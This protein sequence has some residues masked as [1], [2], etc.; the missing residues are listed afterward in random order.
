MEH[1]SEILKKQA[2]A[3][4]S[5]ENT[6]TW[7]SADADPANGNECPVCKGARVVHPRL[8]SGQPDY[9]RT[10]PCRCVKSER[11][12]DRQSRL[13]Q[14]S[15]LGS[16]ARFTFDNL[17]PEGRSS[18]PRSQERFAQVFQAA[19]A[20]AADPKGWL[21]LSGPS[22]GGKTHIA[23]AIVNERLGQ[24]YPAFYI[25]TPDL[26][27]RL[28]ASFNPDSETPYNEFF[29]QVRNAPCSCWMIWECSP[30]LH[31]RKRSSTSC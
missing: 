12:D 6:D 19:K 21:V 20:F 13:K 10:V 23:A 25:T 11:D 4:T 17:M 16:L 22:G 15:N 7:S 27:D 28:R 30:A 5:K 29:D 26:L 18:N 8:S 31:G 1:I 14:Y 24:G 2:R 3:S 9:S